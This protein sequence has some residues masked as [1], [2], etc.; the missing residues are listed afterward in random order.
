VR[1]LLRDST[2]PFLPD[3]AHGYMLAESFLPDHPH[4]YMLAESLLPN[5]AHGYMLAESLLPDHPHGSE[6]LIPDRACMFS[7][8][9]PSTSTKSGA[10]AGAATL[11]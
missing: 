8:V 6:S 5:H 3:H 2:L 9:C 11:A 7:A 10:A 1:R 4:G